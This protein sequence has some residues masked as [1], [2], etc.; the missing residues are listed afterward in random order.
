MK[1]FGLESTRALADRVAARLS[2]PLAVPE[3]RAFEDGEFKIR[4]LESVRNECACIVQT[5]NGD[6]HGSAADKL[7]RVAFFAGS[8]KDAGATEVVAV[9]PY[10]AFSRKDR[11]TKSR[12]PITTRYVAAMLEAVGVDM[13]VTIDV[14]NLA[15]FE[16]AF[17]CRKENLEAAELFVEHVAGEVAL[18][19][20]VVVLS[21]DAGGVH[22]ARA[23]VELLEARAGRSA[24]LAFM[25]K[26]RSAGRVSGEAF[27]GDVDGAVVIVIDDLISGGTT[28]ARAA[29]ACTSRGAV[30]VC[31]VA[32][33]AVFGRTA[34]EALASPD[35]E[36][37]V[38]TDTVNLSS[39]QREALGVKLAVLD[40]SGLLAGALE[41]VTRTRR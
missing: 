36:S 26:K 23:F 34:V 1:L 6:R 4:A 31:C 7:C 13:V 40:S 15:A 30:R 41:R 19:E 25:E 12:D 27:A 29:R 3:E 39:V 10:L 11:R 32:T 21:P 28:M 17:R 18:D 33:H 24:E 22:R 37:V 8:L 16:N 14:H 5:L 2:L 20:R 35:I 38:V 9:L